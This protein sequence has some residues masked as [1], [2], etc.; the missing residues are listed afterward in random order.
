MAFAALFHMDLLPH[1]SKPVLNDL[2]KY[3][4]LDANA[5]PV[6]LSVIDSQIKDYIPLV[7]RYGN[8][9]MLSYLV[10]EVIVFIC[11][12][13]RCFHASSLLCSCS[14]VLWRSDREFL[15]W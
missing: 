11:F 7:V 13:S 9:H 3:V 12:I 8:H 15:E 6:D 14:E 4:H 1:M 5:T 2:I 10:L